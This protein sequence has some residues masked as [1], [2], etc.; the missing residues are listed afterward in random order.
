MRHLLSP[1]NKLIMDKDKTIKRAA[2]LLD[3]L[4]SVEKDINKIKSLNSTNGSRYEQLANHT[5]V[6]SREDLIEA[7]QILIAFLTQRI[8]TKENNYIKE[9][10]S[11]NITVN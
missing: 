3:Q 5:K 1:K 11:I 10:E 8:K 9:F 2:F 4:E 7:N 6:L